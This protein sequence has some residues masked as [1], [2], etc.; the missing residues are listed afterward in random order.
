LAH[1]LDEFGRERYGH[2]VQTRRS[3]KK[4]SGTAPA[5]KILLIPHGDPNSNGVLELF[6]RDLASHYPANRLVRYTLVDA[7]NHMRE[8]TWLGFRALTRRVEHS[9]RPLLST[10]RQLVFSHRSAPDIAAEICS[11]VR[12]EHVD[13]IC[14]ILNSANAIYLSEIL[15]KTCPVPV[16]VI[17]WDD[18]EY[19][20]AGHYFDPWTTR[21]MLRSFASTLSGA[22]HVAVASDGM[23]ELYRLKYKV[24]GIPL[25]HGI[26]PSL[27]R[28]PAITMTSKSS[29]VVGFAGSL[30]C[31]TEWNAFVSAVSDWNRTDAA[32]IR[33][34]FIGR[35]PRFGARTAPFVEHV[36]SLSLPGTLEALATTDVAYVPYW[37]DP[38]RGWAAKTAFPSKISAYVAAGVPV[39]YHGPA[40]STPAS[41]LQRYPVGLSCHSLETAE[42]Q[43]TLRCLLFDE[44]IRAVA[45]REQ[46]RALHEQLGAEAMLCR[47]ARVLGIDRALLLPISTEG[48]RV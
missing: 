47:F 33:I 32:P 44:N 34:R 31:K 42:I 12:Q 39:L 6:L 46:L 2:L 4:M 41:F 37:F 10:L 7:P 25:I 35:F 45:F 14:V 13:L 17:V 20:A 40:E 16:T 43:R 36:G 1:D 30:H 8:G 24:E 5:P 38:R 26:H 22:R 11:L 18:P 27:W 28:A 29:Y 19:L 23:A 48:G 15:T 21:A 9:A 3:A